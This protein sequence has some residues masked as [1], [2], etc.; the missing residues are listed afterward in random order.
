MGKDIIWWTG[1]RLIPNI[2]ENVPEG[3][4]EHLTRYYFAQNMS[5]NKEVLDIASGEGYGTYLLSQKASSVLGIDIDPLAVEHASAKY[6]NDNL[7]YEC[8]S[9][10]DTKLTTNKFDLITCFEMLE[11]IY[12]QEELIDE[13]SRII[14]DDGVFMIS[15]PNKYI[16]ETEV[17]VEEKNHFHV[18]ELYFHEFKSL[19]ESKFP[20][21]NFYSQRVYSVG[22][23]WN[24]NGCKGV[25]ES[26]SLEIQG[27]NHRKINLKDRTAVFF[28]AIVSKKPLN[29]PNEFNLTDT[30]QIIKKDY[31]RRIKEISSTIKNNVCKIY[32]NCGN[33]FSEDENL[34]IQDF[35]YDG[36]FCPVHINIS[37]PENTIEVRIDPVDEM[38]CIV[39]NFSA[40]IHEEELSIYISNCDTEY[41]KSQFFTKTKDPQYIIR[42][43]EK[44]ISQN[45]IISY[46]VMPYV[47][48]GMSYITNIV[49]EYNDLKENYNITKQ[50]LEDEQENY[51][52]TKQKLEDYN[53]SKNKL[54]DI[55]KKLHDKEDELLQMTYL[56]IYREK[57]IELY[58][59]STSWKI[60]AP[61]RFLSRGVKKVVNF[62][63]R[64]IKLI[65]KGLKVFFS[66][67]PIETLRRIKQYI[68]NYKTQKWV[69]EN[70]K[71]SSLSSNELFF[72]S[73]YQEDEDFSNLKT[74]IKALAFYLPQ[75]HTFSENNMWWGDGFTEWTNTKKSKPMFSGHYQP[76]T[77]H[78]D[79]GYYDLSNIETMRKQVELAKKHGIHGFCFYYYWFS[80]KRLME[81]PVDMLLQNQDIDI[82]FCLCWAN[83]NWTRAWDGLSKEILMH[84]EYSKEDPEK[85]IKDIKPY[86]M[87]K[88]YIRIHNKPLI[89]VYNPGEI[90]NVKYLFGQW[91]AQAR[92]QHI[93]EILIWTCQTSNNTAESLNISE[94]IDAEVEFPPHNVW[95]EEIGMK[96]IDLSGKSA[97]IFNYQML[98]DIM[99]KRLRE[100][101][102][103]KVPTH[104]SIMMGW[105]NSARREDNWVTF[106]NFSIH[107]LYRWI[108]AVINRTRVE[109][110]KKEERFI[111]IN[112]WNEW[113]EG[114]Y[115]E[116]D[117]KYGYANINTISKGIFELPLTPIKVIKNNLVEKDKKIDENN[118]SPRIAIQIHLFYTDTIDEII[119]NLN[120]MPYSFDCYISTDTKLKQHEIEVLFK[121]KCKASKTIVDVFPNRGRDVAPFIV[122]MS[123]VINEY[124]YVCHIHSK[125]TTTADYG[126]M[127]RKYLYK[128]LF[129]CKEYL[130]QLFDMF[131]NDARLG[132]IF[133]EIYPVLEKQA[134]WGGN[135]EK[136]EAFLQD[137]DLNDIHLPMTPNFPVGN[138]F[139]MRTSSVLNVF[140]HNI[141]FDMFEEELGQINSTLAHAIERCWVYISEN[142]GYKFK[143]VFNGIKNLP[144]KN[145]LLEL[146]QSR[147]TLFVHFN[148]ENKLTD[149]DLNYI[150]NLKNISDET[151]FISN[152]I[153]SNVDI[154]IIEKMG[155]TVIQRENKGFDFGAWKEVILSYGFEYLQKFDEVVL[156]NNSTYSP[157]IPLENIFNEMSKKSVD[158]W[159]ITLFPYLNDGSYINKECINEHIQSYFQVFNK[160][161]VKSTEFQSFWKNIDYYDEFIELIGNTETELTNV[162]KKANFSYDVYLQESKILCKYL[163]TQSLLYEKPYSMVICGSPFIKKKYLSYSSLEEIIKIKS[164]I[165]N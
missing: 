46:D 92:K 140:N 142:N 91:R 11:H 102:I 108:L 67:G 71:D 131:E 143:K 80:G 86:I 51:N 104:H 20:Y 148:K 2:G 137:L 129:G 63:K 122:Q 84:Q 43:D 36:T 55:R 110:N 31:E 81:K 141:T 50:K 48:P 53:N 60:T 22:Q 132:L 95:F 150:V 30:S 118:N 136:C 15:T 144:D 90:K 3:Y 159:G 70:Y 57:D 89:I 78:E 72:D 77:P 75:F 107:A 16:S 153:I 127:W 128:H 124:D 33:G 149:S 157:L 151:V 56:S 138:M 23:I 4:I 62:S 32:F 73:E 5:N 28:I 35:S 119:N 97:S 93:G 64:F 100:S 12:E 126:D 115:L 121:N 135:L 125:K 29:L 145:Y 10:F 58:K 47:E 105:D 103:K 69:N 27:E 112:A 26:V 158:F 156:V 41:E 117:E 162:L 152:S 154:E 39:K 99:E 74:D 8:R 134:H 109:F 34:Y 1:E 49:Q 18:K 38:N 54:V 19:M 7:K 76:R 37:V 82:P 52:I 139:W 155:I 79:I 120:E 25:T 161:V 146:R 147:I 163:G 165:N 94:Y 164:I 123:S 14:K 6:I 66:K 88:R 106:H 85:F 113:A 87:D 65:F 61:L 45:L 160:N 68:Y 13:V 24:L 40:K 133:P 42:I 114:T 83:E 98:V 111:F 17:H 101:T 116:P 44:N 59:N 130:I 9:A 96:G 21:C